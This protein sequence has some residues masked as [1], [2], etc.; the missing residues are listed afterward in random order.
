MTTTRRVAV[1]SVTVLASAIGALGR[2]GASRALLQPNDEEDEAFLAKARE[3]RAT[4]VQ[5]EVKKS[6]AS[7]EDAGLKQDANTS[8]VQLAV[9]KL[10]KSG[11]DI[12][13]GDLSG[14]ASELASG[15]DWAA[16]AASAAGDASGAFE[17]SVS[18]LASACG[19]GNEDAAKQAFLASAKTLK[20]LAGEAKMTDKLKLL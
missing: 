13:K 14:A 7:T 5:S 3:N 6:R 18:A 16:K 12:A 8:A 20:K 4:R 19:A 9:Y 11:N 1:T 2:P 17:K 10:S 15:G